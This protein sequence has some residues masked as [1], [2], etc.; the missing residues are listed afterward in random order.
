MSKIRSNDLTTLVRI[1]GSGLMVLQ[2][3]LLV[4]YILDVWLFLDSCCNY[5]TWFLGYFD[6][7]TYEDNS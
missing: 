3:V 1:F 6:I 7:F 2:M 5:F 4:H